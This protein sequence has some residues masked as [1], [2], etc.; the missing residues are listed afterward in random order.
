MHTCEQLTTLYWPNFITHKWEGG[1]YKPEHAVNVHNRLKEVLSLRTLHK[2]LS[3]LLSISEQEEM[4]MSQSFEPFDK[5]IPTQY[6]PYTEPIWRAAVTQF[7]NSLAPAERRIAG[8][9]RSQLR[10]MH[11]NTLQL[12]Q[13]FK[14]HQETIKRPSIR[15]ELVAERE[16]LLGK[17]SE[18]IDKERKV[19]ANVGP[20]REVPGV[21]KILTKLYHVPAFMARLKDTQATGEQLLSDLSTWP[22]LKKEMEDFR[23]EI[24]D[25]QREDFDR[26]CRTNLEDIESK[27]LSLQTNAQV[28][29]F[30]AGKDM[31]VNILY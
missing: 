5:L 13:E 22:K 12:L 18:H 25:F 15:R 2:Q 29:Y 28:V 31:K 19:F 26:W 16:S 10:N 6:S 24:K 3:Q 21:P 30:E 1:P 9:L 4:K 23:D 14:R 7:E 20:N 11:G 8:K 27:E 17:L